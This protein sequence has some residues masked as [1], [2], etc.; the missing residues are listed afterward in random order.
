MRSLLP[1]G[2]TVVETYG[3]V[4]DPIPFPEEEEAVA[5]AVEKR[6]REYATVRHCARRALAELGFAPVAI[7]NGARREPLWPEGV[8]GSITHCDGYR[9]AALAREGTVAS[10]GI[11]AE[12]HEVLS[13]GVLALVMR[14]EEHGHLARWAEERPG[15]AWDRVVFSAKE[16]VYKAWFPLTRRWLDFEDATLRIDPWGGTFTAALHRPG[17]VVGGVRVSAMSGRWLVRDGLILTSVVVPAP[18]T[19]P[20]SEPA[21]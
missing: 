19:T 2:V 4:L 9:A 21:S 12:P 18:C 1:P 14:P 20:D 16:S 8:L 13:P 11:D 15:I 6:R 17:P 10:L 3:D 5:R 7:L